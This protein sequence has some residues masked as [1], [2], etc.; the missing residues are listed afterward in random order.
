MALYQPTNITPS[1]FSGFG[2]GVVDVT[3]GME[4]S[5]Q[6]NGNS[7]LVAYEIRIMQNDVNST[8]VLDTGV[9]DLAEPFYGVDYS[10]NVQFFS[11]M[12]SASVLTQSGMANGYANGYKMIITQFWDSGSVEQTSASYFIT[13]TTP[14]LTLGS[15]PSP[16]N[17][18]NFSFTATYT[19]AQGDALEWVR[20]QIAYSGQPD[21]LLLDTMRIYGTADLRADF[22]GFL[23]G[24]TYM[25][26]C[27]VQTVNGVEV[28]TGWQ[29]F[30]VQYQI[31][32]VDGTAT[33]CRSTGHDAVTVNIPS[34]L[35]NA[36]GIT[37][38]A[39]Y[40]QTNGQGVLQHIC[41]L[42]KSAAS[43]MDFGACS[44]QTYQY[45]LYGISGNTYETE[46][47]ATAEI[48]PC[49]WNWTV[50]ACTQDENG[51]FHV[52]EE[53]R[54][55]LD[56]ASGAVTNNNEPELQKNFTPYPTRQP[57]TSN[58]RSGTLT[59]Y[60][61]KAQDGRY[62]D[63]IALMDALR[64]LSTSKMYKFLKTRKGELIRIETSAPISMQ[65]G[66]KYAQQP[67]KIT[68]PWVETMSAKNASIIMDESDALTMSNN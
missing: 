24:N 42:N 66:D 44:Q 56:V 47:A 43:F 12:L 59:G 64:A 28:S 67:A 65:V 50:L 61:G 53:Y 21:E 55:G 17:T 19:Q 27:T 6:V 68:L 3:Q 20:W 36:A 63:S 9:V 11:A 41:D 29:N 33:A 54:F 37:G 32:T 23:T 62:V 45:Y 13:R 40:R 46:S 58:Y 51:V 14:V 15:I 35:A 26:K 2:A 30:T 5:W 7:P 39:V 22:D 16:L 8:P 38:I 34:D 10:G 1:A 4:V 18:R 57:M 60:I 25:V 52:E 48:T 31:A 49:F